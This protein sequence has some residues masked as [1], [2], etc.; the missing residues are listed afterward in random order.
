MRLTSSGAASSEPVAPDIEIGRRGRRERMRRRALIGLAVAAAVVLALACAGFGYLLTLRGVGDAEA[1]VRRIV[2]QHGGTVAPLP[3]PAR[4]GTA[5]VDVEDENFYENVLVNILEG[6]G[7]AALATLQ[8]SGDPGG[9]TINQ[10]LA[11]RLYPHSG[12][13]GGT[14]EEIGLAVKLST[15]Y[16]KAE[17]LNMYLNSAYYGNGYWGDEA[18]ARGYFGLPPQGLSWGEAAL[19]AGVLQAPSAYDPVRH[20]A[21][22]RQRQW[23]VLERLVEND[24]LSARRA[25]AIFREGLPLRSPAAGRR[26]AGE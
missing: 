19:L 17:I 23:H 6:A 7:R 16:S 24:V 13:L 5:V 2:I 18:A 15:R 9:S 3:P 14:L 12:G 21:L 1:R 25:K 20:P 4:L 22:A 26:R 11:K 8:T 10:Q